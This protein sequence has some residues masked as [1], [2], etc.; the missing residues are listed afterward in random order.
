MQKLLHMHKTRRH[1]ASMK[2]LTLIRFA[3]RY[4]FAKL[5]K[6][7]KSH[8]GIEQIQSRR[9]MHHAWVNTRSKSRP[10]RTKIRPEETGLSPRLRNFHLSID[11]LLHITMFQVQENILNSRI[12]LRRFTA[13]HQQ[14]EPRD[15]DLN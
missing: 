4:L 11:T 7:A 5:L 2:P 10:T 6:K 12:V 9:P 13:H 14:T 1:V 3:K 8:E 15:I